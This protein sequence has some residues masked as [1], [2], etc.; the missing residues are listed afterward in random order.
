MEMRKLA[1]VQENR[2]RSMDVK[3]PLIKMDKIA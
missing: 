2:S 3:N 1:E